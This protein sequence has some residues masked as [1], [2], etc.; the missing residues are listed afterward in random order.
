MKSHKIFC[1]LLAA[2]ALVCI[3]LASE[4]AGTAGLPKN[5]PFDKQVKEIAKRH[6]IEPSLVHSIIL[7]ESNYNIYAVSSKGAL[8]LMQLMPATASQ[9]GV[10][11]VFDPEQN[12]EG[13]VRYLKA[14]TKLY[15][16]ERSR[17]RLIVAAYNAGQEAVKK[18]RGI[19]P[20]PETRSYINHV[21]ATYELLPKTRRKIISFIDSDGKV[22]VTND[23]RYASLKGAGKD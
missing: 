6:G 17:E 21:M 12:I 20:Y 9:Y 11:N 13:G 1:C 4:A 8:G 7:H 2:F 14:L 10:L 3:P 23:I 5:L 22:R 15:A 19:P 18:Y 16:K